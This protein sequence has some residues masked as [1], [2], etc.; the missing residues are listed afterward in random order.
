MDATEFETA[1]QADGYTEVGKRPH[2]PN[3]ATEPHT[4]PFDIRAL[5]LEGDI[6]L[7]ADGQ[8]T[9]YGPGEVF[10]MERD[11]EHAERVGPTGVTSL[12]GRRYAA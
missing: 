3:H 9:R 4:H 1:L 5:V 10:V 8:A 7:V 11:R 2:P 12:F 6:T